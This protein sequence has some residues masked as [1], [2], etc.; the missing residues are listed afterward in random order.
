M[1]DYKDC[2]LCVWFI[3]HDS[4]CFKNMS[5]RHTDVAKFCKWYEP[6]NEAA[7]NE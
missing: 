5:P 3:K 4:R 2:S 6:P 7:K 1:S